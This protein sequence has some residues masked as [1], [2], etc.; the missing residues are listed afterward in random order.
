[1]PEDVRVHL[2]KKG[3]VADYWY[4][5]CHGE[6]DPTLP[7]VFVNQASNSTMVESRNNKHLNWFQT[8]VYDTIGSNFGI[9]NNQ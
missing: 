9:Y 2:Y 5:T 7:R 1:M 4:W 6:N 3:F 8:M